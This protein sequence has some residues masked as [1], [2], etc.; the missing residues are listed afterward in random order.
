MNTIFNSRITH[1]IVLTGLFN[2]GFLNPDQ[3]KNIHFFPELQIH[4]FSPNTV[5][6]DSGIY[7]AINVEELEK[8]ELALINIL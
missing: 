8:R 3:T 1:K 6:I 2:F 7:N 4:F 5:C